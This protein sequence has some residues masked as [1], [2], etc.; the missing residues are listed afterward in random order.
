M[1]HVR[2]VAR[3]RNAGG[4][5]S[6]RRKTA[7]RHGPGRWPPP[8]AAPGRDGSRLPV[9]GTAL[10][11]RAPLRVTLHRKAATRP[12]TRALREAAAGRAPA[13]PGTIDTRRWRA[14]A[15]TRSW[16]LPRPA[17]TP[18]RLLLS[19]QTPV[20]AT[21]RHLRPPQDVRRAPARHRAAR[22]PALRGGSR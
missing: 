1:D 16:P 9:P 6:P 3:E 5:Q 2:G 8:E 22:E 20:L 4:D 21:R 12:S 10:P 15:R 7:P 17:R 18:W 19:L 11:A 13:R 14:R